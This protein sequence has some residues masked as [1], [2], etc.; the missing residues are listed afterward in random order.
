MKTP[1]VDPMSTQST[2]TF[3]IGIL[4]CSASGPGPSHQCW[5]VCVSALPCRPEVCVCVHDH[6]TIQPHVQNGSRGS[7]G[8]GYQLKHLSRRTFPS[9]ID[10]PVE[11]LDGRDG[12]VLLSSSLIYSGDDAIS[13]RLRSRDRVVRAEKT[14]IQKPGPVWF[15]IGFGATSRLVSDRCILTNQRPE[16]TNL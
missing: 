8:T 2:H 6:S 10:Q 13:N 9:G 4:D 11:H 5:T 3:Y 15:L 14:T 7:R 12:T 16:K 1:V